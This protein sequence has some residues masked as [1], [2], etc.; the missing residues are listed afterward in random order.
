MQPRQRC[1]TPTF[2]KLKRSDIHPT[3]LHFP[4]SPDKKRQDPNPDFGS[5]KAE[6]L[7]TGSVPAR[8]W[9]VKE[10]HFPIAP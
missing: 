8:R 1:K 7:S 2:T 3:L 10:N 4:L 9:I 6:K 5:R